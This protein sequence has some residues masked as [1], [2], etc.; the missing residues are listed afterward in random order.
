MAGMAAAGAMAS[1]IDASQLLDVD[2][3]QLTRVT[4]FVAVGRLGL[5]EGAELSQPQPFEH[6]RHRRQGHLEMPGD[7]I[8]G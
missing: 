5:V 2:V 7:A 6:E 1:T 3:D 4:A 8:G